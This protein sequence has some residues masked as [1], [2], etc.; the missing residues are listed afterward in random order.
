VPADPRP[1]LDES[2]SGRDGLAH[3]RDRPEGPG[4]AVADEEDAAGPPPSLEKRFFNPRTAVS[5]AIGFGLLVFLLTRAEVDVA[6]IWERIRMANPLLLLL[7]L[8]VYYLVFP[9][10][11]L[12][13]RRL[14]R[15]AGFRGRHGVRLPSVWGL[16]EIIFLSWF[17]NCVVPAKLGDLYRAYLLRANAGVSFSQT[18]GTVLAERIIDLLALFSLMVAAASLAFGQALPAEVVLLMQLGLGLAVIVLIGLLAMR[19]LR[20]VLLGVLPR[21]LH[22]QYRR[23]EDGTLHSFRTLPSVVALTGLA[24]VGEITRLTLVTSALGVTGVAPSVLVFV[25]LA[26]ALATTLPVTPAGLGVAEGTIVGIF[27]LAA[28]AG[29]APGVDQ[30]TAA[31]IAIVDRSISYWSLVVFGFI[32]Y[33]L[34]RRK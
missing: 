6:G 28:R 24:W 15:N 27:L 2:A 19:N 13:W 33:L 23:F 34:S 3:D 5:F 16:S 31:S 1:D 22:A 11:A 20:P 25:A 12:R 29:L 21:R 9:V 14:L 30:H 18:M 10:R 32:G 7:G 26:A 4:D 8:L 17:A